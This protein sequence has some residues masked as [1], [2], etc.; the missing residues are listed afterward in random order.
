MCNIILLLTICYVQ[1]SAQS[2]KLKHMIIT[3]STCN[4]MFTIHTINASVINQIKMIVLIIPS[5]TKN[6]LFA[7]DYYYIFCTVL[8]QTPHISIPCLRTSIMR[9][10]LNIRPMYFTH[11]ICH[12]LIYLY[13]SARTT[14]SPNNN[15][16]TILLIC[17]AIRRTPFIFKCT[18]LYSS[19]TCT[20]PYHYMYIRLLFIE[21]PKVYTC[22]SP[23]CDLQ[24]YR[25]VHLIIITMSSY[26]YNNHAFNYIALCVLLYITYTYKIMVLHTFIERYFV[27]HYSEQTDNYKLNFIIILTIENMISVCMHLINTISLLF[28]IVRVDYMYMYIHS[29]YFGVKCF[30]YSR[31]ERNRGR[32]LPHQLSLIKHVYNYIMPI[33]VILYYMTY[34]LD[35]L[36][37][38][39]C[40]VSVYT[41][42]GVVITSS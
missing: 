6:V 33:Y 22:I 8:H 2:S 1:H 38:L 40:M 25:S 5:S 3:N 29:F 42:K 19:N 17:F 26:I 20:C 31:V 12:L 23:H 21:Y 27:S 24:C 9:S 37:I 15:T 4:S 7:I 35:E 13:G 18:S 32:N 14:L 10:Q 30:M 11:L 34:Y 28:V 41:C 16:S 36:P 39:F